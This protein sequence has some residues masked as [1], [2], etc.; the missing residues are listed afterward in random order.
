MHRRRFE[1]PVRLHPL[2][3]VV[4][5]RRRHKARARPADELLHR[6]SA[7]LRHLAVNDRRELVHRDIAPHSIR[8][9]AISTRN[10]SPFDN[11]AK[12]RI[13]AGMVLNPTDWQ[14][15]AIW[16]IEMPFGKSSM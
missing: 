8:R 12:G 13:H 6:M 7:D 5:A 3:D 16:L 14:I 4:V 2:N 9:R 15:S 11:T 1:N 10:F